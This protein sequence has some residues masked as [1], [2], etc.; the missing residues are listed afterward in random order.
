MSEELAWLGRARPLNNTAAARGYWCSESSMASLVAEFAPGT[1]LAKF[2]KIAGQA[3]L[4]LQCEDCGEAYVSTSRSDAASTITRDEEARRR[5]K[6]DRFHRCAKC[7]RA[8]A[9]QKFRDDL[10]KSQEKQRR[11]EELRWMPYKDYLGTDEWSERRKKV[12]LRAEFRCQVCATN[13]RLHVHHRTYIRRGV[14][15][16]ED[17]IALC[18]DCHALFHSHGKLSEGGRAA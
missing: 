7:E 4:D 15:R 12:I 1:S 10:R 17:M 11:A 18:A 2:S 8:Y 14:E 9:S 13:G 6:Q 16:I 5:G 3:I